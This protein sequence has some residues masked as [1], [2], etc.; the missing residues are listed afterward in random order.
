MIYTINSETYE[1]LESMYRT[2]EP[3]HAPEPSNLITP[4][5]Q[6]LVAKSLD[7]FLELTRIGILQDVS[8]NNPDLIRI[9][10]EEKGFGLRVF[11]LSEDGKALFRF[12]NST[13]N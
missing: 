1:V 10:K 8:S 11:A 12:K 7:V 4:E 6:D 2:G 5:L 13:L 3:I 9:C